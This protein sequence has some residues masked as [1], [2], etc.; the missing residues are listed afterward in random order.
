MNPK[1]NNIFFFSPGGYGPYTHN[2][3][4]WAEH[5]DAEEDSDEWMD[6]ADDLVQEM[7]HDVDYGLYFLSRKNIE[8]LVETLKKLLEE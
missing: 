2:L 5:V 6:A 7:Q 4:F 1:R 8:E 3:E